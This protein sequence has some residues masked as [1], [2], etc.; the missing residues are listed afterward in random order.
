VPPIVVRADLSQGWDPL[1]WLHLDHGLGLSYVSP[2][3]LPQSERSAPAFTL[4]LATS[5]KAG[6]VQVGVS[7]QNLLDSRYPL[8][9]YNF[10]S[11][12][13][14]TSGADFPTRVPARHVIYGAPRTFL[15]SVTFAPESFLK[16]NLKHSHE[17]AR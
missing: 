2:R 10:S 15:A 3:P 14:D 16:E 6:P 4:D 7:V 17:E 12:F 8:A 11:W 1:R 13:P 5:A 9:E